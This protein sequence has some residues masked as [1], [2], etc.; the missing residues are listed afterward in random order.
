MNP[1][2]AKG[3]T[4][5]LKLDVIHIRIDDRVLFATLDAPPLNLIGPDIVRDLIRLVQHLEE[6]EDDISVVV[7]DSAS[8]DFFS[9]HVDIIAL[10][11]M[12]EE[13]RRL[14]RD[15]SLRTLYRR[16]STLKQVTIASIAGRCAGQA[17]PALSAVLTCCYR[18]S[19]RESNPFLGAGR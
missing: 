1:Y 14:A 13:L 7:F 15:A 8:A 10:P 18:W 16:I 6:H 9:A 12:R 2:D 11:A 19:C 17:A 5:M 4:E 3:E